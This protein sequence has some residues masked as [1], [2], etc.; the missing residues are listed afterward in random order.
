MFCSI[1]ACIGDLCVFKFGLEWKLGRILQ[2]SRHNTVTKKYDKPC[3][4]QSV[5]VTKHIGVLCSWYQLSPGSESMFE[6]SKNSTMDYH[7]LESYVCTLPESCIMKDVT[8]SDDTLT[9]NHITKP[10]KQSSLTAKQIFITED[11]TKFLLS[12]VETSLQSSVQQN[13]VPKRST[14]TSTTGAIVIPD[15]AENDSQAE[16]VKDLWT[17]CGGILLGRRELQRLLNDKELSDLHINAF[18]NL[19]KTQFQSI[20]GLQSTLFQ[21]K[22]LPLQN[23]QQ[24]NLQIIH[25]TINAA[26]KHWAVLEMNNDSMICLYDSA[27]TSGVGNGKNIIAQ[28]LNTNDDT[29]TV[30]IMDVGKQVGA[31]DCGLYAIATL[32]CLAHDKD[33]CSIVFKKEELRPHLQQILETGQLKEFPSSQRRKRRSRILNTEVCEVHCICRMPDD[34]SKMVCCDTCNKWFHA[35]CV[36]YN[37]QI[38]SWY[39]V[40]CSKEEKSI[41]STHHTSELC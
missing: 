39:C 11:C 14:S 24:K 7:S 20:G 18:Q 40:E 16:S 22:Q 23:K 8:N 35:A 25:V 6:L 41:A 9:F 3:N 26:I 2:L 30:N 32:T 1:K 10:A 15:N 27:Y 29:F 37:D 12:I 19:V 33:P 13:S 4:D 31:A 17:R 36:E 5:E 28:L 34:G 21:Q 38:K